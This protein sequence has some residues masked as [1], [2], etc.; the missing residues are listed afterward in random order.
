MQPCYILFLLCSRS[1]PALLS[2]L[3]LP[4]SQ[5]TSNLRPVI[6]SQL[7][8]YHM[9]ASVQVTLCMRL[10]IHSSQ[11]ILAGAL[12]TK[13]PFTARSNQRNFPLCHRGL[14]WR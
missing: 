3:K 10:A 9:W 11:G 13:L 8:Q 14:G 6:L 2:C 4:C 12:R 7:L 5:P 1:T